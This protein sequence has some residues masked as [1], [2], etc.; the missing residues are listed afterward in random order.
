MDCGGILF[1]DFPELLKGN[2][3]KIPFVRDEVTGFRL[4]LITAQLEHMTDIFGFFQVRHCPILL[5]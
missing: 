3:I 4:P 5:F 2:G 1:D